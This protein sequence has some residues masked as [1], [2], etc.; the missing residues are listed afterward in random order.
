[1]RSPV[2]WKYSQGRS[3]H[4][5]L[6][7]C[8]GSTAADNA[9]RD[10]HPD[11]SLAAKRHSAVRSNMILNASQLRLDFAGGAV[12][13]RF[14]RGGGRDHPLVKAAG[15]RKDRIPT[16]VDATAGLGRDAFLLASVGAKVVLLERSREVHALLEDALGR[17][18]AASPAL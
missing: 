18:R 8:C 17:A 6:A 14:R 2:W 11:L 10:E 5:S 12:G 3:A 9:G 13:F 1:M 4:L 15:F 7:R 16:V